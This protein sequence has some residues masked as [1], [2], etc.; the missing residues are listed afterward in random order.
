MSALLTRLSVPRVTAWLDHADYPQ[1][2]PDRPVLLFAEGS[3]PRPEEG[4]TARH[5]PSAAP[6]P[7]GDVWETT[8]EQAVP[9]APVPNVID[10]FNDAAIF[11]WTDPAGITHL[12]ICYASVNPG[13]VLSRRS[14]YPALLDGAHL[15]HRSTRHDSG[16]P[17]LRSA[18]NRCGREIPE[19]EGGAGGDLHLDLN[20]F[21]GKGMMVNSSILVHPGREPTWTAGCPMTSGGYEDVDWQ[22]VWGHTGAAG[23]WVLR[24]PGHDLLRWIRA[25]GPRH[26]PPVLRPGANCRRWVRPLQRALHVADDGVFGPQTAAALLVHRHARGLSGEA[27]ALGHVT[28][29]DCRALGLYAA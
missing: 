25:G 26:V 29:D 17:C 14:G 28:P 24:H 21:T 9:V 4:S 15:Y 19:F 12:G 22:M 6:G 16:A 3:E 20:E 11:L 13:S 23:V 2:T 10:A 8:G 7:W 1:P 27:A 5:W 18:R